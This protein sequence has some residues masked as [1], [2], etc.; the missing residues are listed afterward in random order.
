MN[1]IQ[2]IHHITAVCSDA[3]A[4][5]DFY[6]G[7]LG[8]RLVKKTVNF[9][10]PGTYHL[11]YG[12]RVGTPGTIM[13][14]FPWS[15]MGRGRP[16]VGETGAVA[17][18]IP[19]GA[20]GFWAEH[21]E[22]HGVAVSGVQK[23]FGEDVLICT[24]P[25]GMVVE[26]VATDADATVASWPEGPIPE[27]YALRGFHS[28]TL[29]LRATDRTAAL[30]TEH[31]G[32]HNAAQ[33]GDRT[34]LSS[35]ANNRAIHIDL[36]ERPETPKGAFGAGSV[37]HVAFRTVDDDEQAQY[38]ALL[39]GAGQS[40][41]P[42]KDRQYFHS[43]YFREPGGVL[44]EIATDAPGFLYDEDETTLGDALKLPPWL[45]SRRERIEPRLRPLERASGAKSGRT[46]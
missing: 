29:W 16:G 3:Q 30:L 1:P 41:T 32:Y 43:V 19:V 23:R 37:H 22:S 40:V 5:V 44:F 6:E 45:E 10:D 11:Y 21:L 35:P 24:D 34:R 46:E 38:Q 14:F 12:D 33:E 25:D 20:I 26:L 27:K 31:L 36:C 18:S 13:T 42:V 7:V 28:V 4:N 9:D 15:H 39:R 2:G 8:Q 17:W